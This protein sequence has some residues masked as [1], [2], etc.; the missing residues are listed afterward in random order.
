MDCAHTR[1]VNGC[2]ASSHT[3]DKVASGQWCSAGYV[4]GVT[5]LP[6]CQCNIGAS[7]DM[8][9]AYVPG[10]RYIQSCCRCG[11]SISWRFCPA[12]L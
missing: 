2:A 3:S 4:A 12:M 10:W 11:V 7:N 6:G 9:I 1:G 5:N 8:S